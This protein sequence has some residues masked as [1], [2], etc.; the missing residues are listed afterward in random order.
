M[1]GLREKGCGYGERPHPRETAL[2]VSESDQRKSKEGSCSKGPEQRYVDQADQQGNP[3]TV[4]PIFPALLD[5]PSS[6]A[7]R[8]DAAVAVAIFAPLRCE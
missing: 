1:S 5:R 7:S 6:F 3:N 8:T 2:R 4:T